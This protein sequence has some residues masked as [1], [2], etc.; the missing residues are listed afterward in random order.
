[1]SGLV[2]AHGPFDPAVGQRMLDRLAHRGPDGRDL[3]SA[4]PARPPPAGGVDPSGAPSRCDRRGD[5]WLVGDGEVKNHE[6]LWLWREPLPHLPPTTGGAAPVEDAGLRAFE[7]LWG[8]FASCSPARMALCRLPRRAG[9]RT[10][11]LGLS[12][13]Y[14]PSP[15]S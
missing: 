15:R 7:R 6:D 1:M 10:A 9:H 4:A 3:L 2:A 5:L 11:L 14:D 12:G 8:A 13:R